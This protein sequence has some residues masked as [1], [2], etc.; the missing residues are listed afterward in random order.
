MH[1][2][3]RHGTR[4]SH[5]LAPIPALIPIALALASCA[6]DGAELGELEAPASV[7]Q[8]YTDTRIADNVDQPTALAFTPDGR[9]LVTT[10]GGAVRVVKNGSLLG[11]AALDLS[12]KLCTTSE[13]GLLGIA[14]DPDFASNKYVYLFYTFKKGSGCPTKNLSGGPVNRVSRFTYNTSNDR[15]DAS[16]ETVLLDNM[17]SFAGNHNG[18]DIKIGGDGKL[19]VSLGD[20]GCQIDAPSSCG[21]GNAN[22]KSKSILSGKILRINRDGSI[23]SDNP[24]VGSAGARRCGQPGGDPDYRLDNSR[25]CVET[26]AWR[27]RN[28]FRIAFKPDGNG[29]FINDVG[30]NVWEEIDEGIKGANYG[31]N[32]R[33]G[34][35]KNGSTSDCGAPPAGTTNPIFAYGRGDDCKSITGGAF[36]PDGFGLDGVYLFGDYVCGNIF[37]LTRN[38]SS[39]RRS[40]FITGFGAN[41]VVAMAFG[42][43]PG[44]GQSLYYTIYSSG[45]EVHRVD[46]TGAAN[47]KPTAVLAASPRSGPAPLEVSFN[48]DA[49]TDPDGDSID[50]YAF[51]FGDGQSISGSSEHVSY[52]YTRTGS[53]QAT[54]VV[55]D[56]RGASSD[57]VSVTI[58]PGNTPPTVTIT[59]PSATKK[60]KVGEVI[61]LRGSASDPQDGALPVEWTVI[62]HHN[63]HTHP[64][65][66]PTVGDSVNVTMEGPEDLLAASNSYFEIQAKATDRAGSSTVVTRDL[67]AKEVVLTFRSEPT[68]LTLVL[69]NTFN[70][71]APRVVTSWEAHRFRVQAPTQTL[72]GHRYVF[73][74]WSDGGA[75]SHDLTTPAAA[76]TYT[77]TFRDDGAAFGAKVDFRPAGTT[78]PAGYVA[79]NGAVFASR[80]G[81]RYGWN[82]AN[83]NTRDRNDPTSPDDRYDTLNHMQKP[84]NPNAVWEIEVPNGS[85]DVHVVMGDAANINSVYRLNAEGTL[86]VNGTPTAS[87]RWLE[88]TATVTVSDGRLTLG[89]ASGAQNNKINFVELVKR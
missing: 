39:Y 27:L 37:K 45:G 74:H 73:D 53:F 2:S 3:A 75:A 77:A 88:G 62:R 31:W 25:P 71:T 32:D 20:S 6:G 46:F 36:A 67:R 34:F 63:D 7:P 84:N 57:P 47:R 83:D 18:G 22:T 87:Q 66:P 61:N 23:P 17:L 43:R 12:G 13:R 40:D 19:Y 64:F 38:G 55:T 72:N 16:S 78:A 60:F 89:N 70:A 49:S 59:A 8:S 85:Y 81:L 76:T 10:Q 35:C 9:V 58:S 14:V 41:S 80:N 54:L 24:W 11:T 65:F 79:D 42:P 48:G 86:I 28:P 44:G 21:G 1:S 56:S 82:A 69:D 29:F 33:E 15:I 30:Q 52:T 50:R 4:L 68:G 5:I 26:Y 51:T